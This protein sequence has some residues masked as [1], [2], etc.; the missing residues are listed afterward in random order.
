MTLMILY[1]AIKAAN[2]AI[3]MASIEMKFILLLISLVVGFYLSTRLF[4]ELIA[5]Y[6]QE[7]MSHSKKEQSF[8]CA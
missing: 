6:L 7:E 5:Q 4:I 2:S 3:G 1:T 8:A